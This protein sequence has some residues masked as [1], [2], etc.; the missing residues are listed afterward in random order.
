MYNTNKSI[1]ID[2]NKK[3]RVGDSQ[4]YFVFKKLVFFISLHHFFDSILSLEL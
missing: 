4:R 1:L 2:I 3:T